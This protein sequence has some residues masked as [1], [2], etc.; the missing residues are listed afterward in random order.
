MSCALGNHPRR[1]QRRGRFSAVVLVCAIILLGLE[2]QD[3]YGQDSSETRKSRRDYSAA[4]AVAYT[5]SM[6]VLDDVRPLKKGDQLSMRIV[7]DK[8]PPMPLVVSDSG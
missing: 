1:C 6:A 5:N 7:E 2:L 3:L 8:K 4:S